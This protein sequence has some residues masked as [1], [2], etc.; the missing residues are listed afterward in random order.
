MSKAK[1]VTQVADALLGGGKKS[2]KA[3]VVADAAK[4]KAV[5]KTAIP[6]VEAGYA[7]QPINLA[8]A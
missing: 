4:R 6:V 2:L 5:Q 8:K 7:G 3:D 1:L